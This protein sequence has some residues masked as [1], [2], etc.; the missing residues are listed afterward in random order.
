MK[1]AKMLADEDFAVFSG[2]G[3]GIMEAA[4]RGAYESEKGDSVGLNIQLKYEQRINDYIKKQ[5]VFI[6]SLLGR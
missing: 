5:W 1:L 4:N 6:I 2:G 3:P